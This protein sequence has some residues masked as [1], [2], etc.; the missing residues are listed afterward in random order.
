MASDMSTS[1]DEDYFIRGVESE[2]SLYSHY[3]WMPEETIPFAHRLI[4]ALAI[5]HGASVLDFGC[6]RGYLVRALCLLGIRATGVD[7]STW[8]IVNCDGAVKNL[9]TF[10]GA[11]ALKRNYDIIIAKDVLEHIEEADLGKTLEQLREHGSRLF[12]IVPLGENGK[13]VIPSH[14]RDVTHR[15][16]RPLDWWEDQ[17]NQTEWV[18]QR[19]EHSMFGFKEGWLK[20]WPEGHGFIIAE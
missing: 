11:E 12:V 16:R 7:I 20:R 6:A 15:I 8:A 5:P 1:Y 3:R 2:K 18:V 10:G 19:A 17:F 14:E 9:V 13:Y 4:D